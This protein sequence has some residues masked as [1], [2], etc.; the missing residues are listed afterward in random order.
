[1]YHMFVTNNTFIT[2]NLITGLF[3][4]NLTI[5]IST[6][7]HSMFKMQMSDHHL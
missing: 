3:T 4:I 6:V 2:I 5:N 7:A 1:M